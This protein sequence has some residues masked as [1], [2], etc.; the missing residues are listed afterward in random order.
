MKFPQTLRT[1]CIYCKKH[2]MHTVEIS[3]KRTRGSMTQGQRRYQRKLKGYGSFPR[4]KPD[5]EKVTKKVDL[6]YKCSE[7]GKKHMRGQ[8]W[9]AKKFE[10][11][12]G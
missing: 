12:K 5:H 2:T 10:L 11:V 9:R 7:C 3:K 1:Y 6:R 4:P 8:G